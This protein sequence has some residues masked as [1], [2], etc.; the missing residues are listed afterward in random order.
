M[1]APET[2][3]KIVVSGIGQTASYYFGCCSPPSPS[4]FSSSFL[5]LLLLFFF[6]FSFFILLFFL[7]FLLLLP[8]LIFFLFFIFCFFS[9]SSSS[10]SSYAYL[11]WF[12]SSFSSACLSSSPHVPETNIFIV[13][14]GTWA[15]TTPV[16]VCAWNHYKT[17]GFRHSQG[18]AF[19]G[20][21]SPKSGF[22][23][24][25]SRALPKHAETFRKFHVFPSLVRRVYET[26]IF[27]VFSGLH[28]APS[29]KNA[30]F[31]KPLKTRDR[32]TNAVFERFAA[33]FGGP[34]PLFL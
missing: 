14:S 17:S 19:V 31:W 33:V 5:F 12:A 16:C 13:I 15:R 29:S 7:S 20:P 25:K 4:P 22:F 27:I 9:S 1:G 34:K 6:F 18:N 28:E 24:R 2:T 8:L 21:R 3:I 32:E 23:E 11:S 30:L 26:P 10:S